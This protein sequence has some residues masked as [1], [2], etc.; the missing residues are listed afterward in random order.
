MY[1]KE[2]LC[3]VISRVAEAYREEQSLRKS[4]LS[5]IIYFLKN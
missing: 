1:I 5:M 2:K 3:D 4:K